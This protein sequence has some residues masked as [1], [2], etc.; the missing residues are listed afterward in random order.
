[1]EKLPSAFVAR[2][3]DGESQLKVWREYRAFSQATVAE[4]AGISEAE[5]LNMEAEILPIP[6]VIIARL[7]EILNVRPEQIGELPGD[8]LT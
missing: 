4:R 1:M 2:I 6:D 5:L 3:L 7:A 8:S